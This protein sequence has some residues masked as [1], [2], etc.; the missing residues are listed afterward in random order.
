MVSIGDTTDRWLLC[1]YDV[2]EKCQ[3]CG[4]VVTRV[5][6]LQK[7]PGSTSGDY[8][9]ADCASPTEEW[10]LVDVPPC[11]MCGGADFRVNDGETEV[12]CHSASCKFYLMPMKVDRWRELYFNRLKGR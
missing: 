10:S 9:C 3:R 6:L 11:P 8:W 2:P 1:E 7:Y 12:W 5:W 4:K